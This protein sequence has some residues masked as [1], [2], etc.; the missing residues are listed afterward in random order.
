MFKSCNF[1]FVKHFN[2]FLIISAILIVTGVIGLV[3]LPFGLNLFNMDV[4]FLGGVTMTYDLGEQADTD[5]VEDLARGVLEGNLSS[6]TTSGSTGTQVVIKSLFVDVDTRNV[7]T[8]SIQET[9]PNATV[10]SSSSVSASVS[11]DLRNSAILASLVAVACMLIYIGIR[12]DFRSGLAAVIAL[13]H[14][15]LVMLSAYII[16]RIPFNVN[17]IA[18][19]L[20]ILGYSIN[21]TI[22]VFDRAREN[23][24]ANPKADFGDVMDRSI[25]QTMTRSINTTITTLLTITMVIILGVTSIRNFCW[26]LFVGVLAGCYSSVCISGNVWT[27]LRGIKHGGNKEK[28]AA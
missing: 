20:T 5:A 12:F 13:C 9:Y 27:R 11:E 4:D 18:A 16:F 1:S 26:P 28:K 7:L 23:A 14:D 17:F 21:A 2:L 25:W 3:T 6:V 10:V 8:E 24:K 22:V 15:L 19:A